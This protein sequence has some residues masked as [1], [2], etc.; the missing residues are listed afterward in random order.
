[1]KHIKNNVAILVVFSNFIQIFLWKLFPSKRP[2]MCVLKT[3]SGFVF[4]TA[5]VNN[6]LYSIVEIWKD[7]VYGTCS[8]LSDTTI[9]LVIDIGA[10]IGAFSLFCLHKN[11]KAKVYAYEPEAVNFSLLS[12]NVQANN[13]TSQVLCN[14][15]AVCADTADRMLNIVDQSSGKNSLVIDYG[16]G[17]AQ[18]VQCLSLADIF[19]HHQIH[20]CDVLKIDCEGSEYEI[21][22]SAPEELFIRI[23]SIV[24]EYHDVAGYGASDIVTFLKRIGYTI[25]VQERHCS[26]FATR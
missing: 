3:W 5:N 25:S 6:N 9:P 10:N 8:L 18:R 21:L 24:L 2:E 15:K 12:K 23:K 17:N 7:H 26:I 14:K 16:H 1:M 4:Y 22:F 13:A 19:S 20:V 11:P